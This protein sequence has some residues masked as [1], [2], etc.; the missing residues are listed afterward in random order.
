[1]LWQDVDGADDT[2]RLHERLFGRSQPPSSDLVVVS[3]ASVL[4][5]STGGT[6]L[7]ENVTEVPAAQQAR[8][9]RLLRDRELSIDG[10]RRP[11]DVRVVATAAPGIGADVHEG[12]FRP[13]LFRRLAANRIDMPPLRDRAADLP[14]LIETLVETYSRPHAN[15]LLRLTDAAVGLLAVLDWPGNL[16]QLR[17]VVAH[18]VASAADDLIPVEAVL[19]ALPLMRISTPFVPAASLRDA[20]QRFERD[21]IAS[22]LQ[23]HGW[24]MP[25]AA[26]TLGI[27]RPNLY[28]KARQLG[29][30]LVRTTDRD[31]PA[32]EER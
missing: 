24:R 26:R 13:D 1:L 8:L 20:R 10:V 2:G 7:I 6:L 30:P 22:V 4:G 3:R 19:P 23:H 21:Y 27:Q 18:I 31:R 17:G 11:L 9:A 14:L 5:R 32:D 28:R 15:A 25:D 29:I 12:R 16:A